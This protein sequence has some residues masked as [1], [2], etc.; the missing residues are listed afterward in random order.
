MNRSRFIFRAGWVVMLGMIL[1]AL[2]PRAAEVANREPLT[3]LG[4]GSTRG[5]LLPASDLQLSSRAAGVVEKFGTDEGKPVAEGD[6]LVQLNS[7][8]E[9]ADL[10]RAEAVLESTEAE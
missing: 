8:I 6:L 5:I 10:A 7:D 1:P 9:R 4:R 3:G 2:A